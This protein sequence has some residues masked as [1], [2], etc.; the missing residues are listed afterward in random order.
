[1]VYIS[2][3]LLTIHKRESETKQLVN[4]SKANL[5]PM[6]GKM[7]KFRKEIKKHSLKDRGFTGMHW[8]QKTNQNLNQDKPYAYKYRSPYYREYNRLGHTRDEIIIYAKPNKITSYIFYD[9]QQ[10]KLFFGVTDASFTFHPENVIHIYSE[11]HNSLEEIPLFIDI[12]MVNGAKNIQKCKQDMNNSPIP[13]IMLTF[14]PRLFSST[15]D[16]HDIENPVYGEPNI[17]NSIYLPYS[18]LHKKEVL[19]RWM[20]FKAG[21]PRQIPQREVIPNNRIVHRV[22]EDGNNSDEEPLDVRRDRIRRERAI[23]AAIEAANYEED[24][25]RLEDL[26]APDRNGYINFNDPV[27]PVNYDVRYPQAIFRE[28][29]PDDDGHTDVYTINGEFFKFNPERE[30]KVLPGMFALYWCPTDG[31]FGIRYKKETQ[32]NN[33]REGS[34]NGEDQREQQDNTEREIHHVVNKYIYLNIL[35]PGLMAEMRPVNIDFYTRSY[36]HLARLNYD[37]T[38]IRRK[39]Q[40]SIPRTEFEIS[41]ENRLIN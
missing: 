13:N 15:F 24:V 19:K 9:K 32:Q 6:S 33:N 17:I 14:R 18:G 1:M 7:I 3:I 36:Y 28:F 8:Y 10:S 40:V 35:N 39:D 26:P 31:S 29:R 25:I 2:H 21:I 4:L 38:N 12:C 41:W 22:V 23:Q 16:L 34:N 11:E 20:D 30:E 27:W 37:E 5:R